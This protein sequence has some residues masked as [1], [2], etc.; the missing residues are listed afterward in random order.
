MTSILVLRLVSFLSLSYAI[1]GQ[2]TQTYIVQIQN[3][4]KPSVFNDVDAWYN[5]MLNTLSSSSIST[6][7]TLSN[8]SSSVEFIHLY[9]TVFNG[10]SAKLT[11]EQVQDLS[12][13]REV[14]GIIPDIVYQIHTT[15]TPEFLGLT[16]RNPISLLKKSNGGS[17]VVIG[18]FDTGIFP[19]SSS[20]NDN[21]MGPIP[22]HWKGS[23]EN[24]DSFTKNHC[25]K[26]LIGARVFSNGYRANYGHKNSDVKSPR[27]TEGHGT[28]T[29][30]TAAGRPITNSSFFGFAKGTATGIAPKARVAVYKVCWSRGC[31][32]SD[33]LAALDM[34]VRDGVNVMSISLGG[35]GSVPYFMDP[36]AIGSFGAVNKGVF[37]SASAGN[38]GPRP[39]SVTNV[40]PWITTIGASTIDRT[41]PVD[42]I[43]GDGSIITGSSIYTG[44]PFSKNTFHPIILGGDASL[45]PGEYPKKLA[46]YCISG[47]L[48]EKVVHG[49][50]VVC[51]RGYSGR[52]AKG[53]VVKKAG[54][55]GMVIENTAE[56]GGEGLLADAHLLPALAITA[57]AG[58]KLH[59]YMNSDSNPKVSMKFRGT[60]V[61]IKPAPVVASF[62]SR[63]PNAESIYVLK[64]DVI[65]PGVNILAAWPESV[66]P[67]ELPIDTRRS[68]FNII[69]GTSM[70]CPHVSGLAALLKGANP[71]WSP[72]MIR[73]AL[74]TTAYTHYANDQNLLDENLNSQANV[75]ATGA[76]HVD[77]E[78]AVDPGLVYDMSVDDYSNFMCASGYTEDMIHRVSRQMQ[79]KCRGN[80]EKPWNLNYPAIMVALNRTTTGGQLE[81]KRTATHVGYGRGVYK[82][83][84]TAPKGTRVTVLPRVLKFKRMGQK[85]SYVVR[86]AA[87][88]TALPDSTEYVSAGKLTWVDRKHHVTSPIVV[89]WSDN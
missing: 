8:T 83:M 56:E 87:Q 33:V 18:F 16:T 71:D 62:S 7:S 10:F 77:P 29:A 19:E 24:G 1:L 45:I 37:I 50:I 31:M 17:N 40:A 73:S 34:A 57:S 85:L 80:T 66:S 5:S 54:G 61:G 82:V 41:F 21:G 4:H 49:K 88:G 70:S 15:R 89:T 38:S 64:P 20:F 51:K 28:H 86:V 63:G 60:E 58:I 42:L 22:S 52:A 30:S 23:C 14:L 46:S 2:K 26:K 78:K 68:K 13:K 67:T 69:S 3:D 76:G 11:E 6:T 65:A 27:D 48:D 74:M 59:D 53:A 43:L 75:W 47:T 12:R 32:S 81:A 36:I 72:A 39:M 79:F 9:T 25:N 44:K 35:S 84:V 55:I